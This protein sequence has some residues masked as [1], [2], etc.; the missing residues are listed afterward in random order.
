MLTIV[1][2]SNTFQNINIYKAI[3]N[4]FYLCINMIILE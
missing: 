1:S 4:I 3:T 2:F